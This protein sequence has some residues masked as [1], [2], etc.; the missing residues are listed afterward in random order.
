MTNQLKPALIGKSWRRS[1]QT[2]R[3]R[4]K[5]GKTEMNKNGIAL[6]VPFTVYKTYCSRCLSKVETLTP[7]VEYLAMHSQMEKGRVKIVCSK[8]PPCKDGKWQA[9]LWSGKVKLT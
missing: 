9:V 5:E 6:E 8:Q 4:E 2:I 1:G 7:L 3:H